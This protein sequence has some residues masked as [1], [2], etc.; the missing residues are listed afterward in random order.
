MKTARNDPCPC[1][2]GRKYKKCCGVANA[3]ERGASGHHARR[4]CGSCTACC[5]GWL[6]IVIRG[7]EVSPNHPCP[8]SQAGNCA[9]YAERPEDPCR[10]FV[11][12]WL[13]PGSPF[14]EDFR[15]DRIHTI[16]LRSI[17]RGAPTYGLVPAGADP[18]DRL[19]AW[20]EAFA[21]RTGTPFLFVRRGQWY[22]HGPAEFQQ[23][24]IARLARG[25]RFWA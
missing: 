21:A 3:A 11:C 18:D 17:W 15:P 13:A 16:F 22:A 1:G 14:P 19:I 23:E 6:K 2:S 5:D 12:G 7:V 20:M 9:I 8:Y 24:V 4:E 25:E 10:K